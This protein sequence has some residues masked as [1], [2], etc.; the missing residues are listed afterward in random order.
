MEIVTKASTTL[1][2]MRHNLS[3]CSSQVKEPAYLMMVRSQVEYALDVWDS[4]YFGDITVW[5]QKKYNKEH[6]AGY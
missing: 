6:P 3:N 5:N 4:H 1:N 2:F